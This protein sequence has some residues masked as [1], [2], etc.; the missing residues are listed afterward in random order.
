MQPNDAANLNARF[1]DRSTEDILQ[2]SIQ[3]LFNERV[4]LVCSFGTESA[5]L[6]HMVATIDRALPILFLNTLKHFEE[7]IEYRDHLIDRLG[8]TGVRSIQPSS[9][10]IKAIDP[11]G[12]LWAGNP[13]TCC[14]LRKVQP[15][16]AE[17][18]RFDA[19]ITG[20]KQH[21]GNARQAVQI[22]EPDGV[23]L[24]INPLAGWTRDKVQEYL[25]GHDLP[26]HPLESDGYPSVGCAV[27]T[28]RVALGEAFR[29]GR[30]RGTAK[31]ECGLHLPSKRS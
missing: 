2:I 28:S 10:D 29:A 1:G 16:E 5:V 21:H 14:S 23:R 18:I 11:H 25:D 6:L 27:C 8:L 22:F 4:A 20:R 26:R 17:S 19:L 7:T 9:S 15:L 12:L 13:D 3:N 30:W 31:T 24:K